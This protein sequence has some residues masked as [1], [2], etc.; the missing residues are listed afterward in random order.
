MGKVSKPESLAHFLRTYSTIR[1]GS[2]TLRLQF[3]FNKQKTKKMGFPFTKPAFNNSVGNHTLAFVSYW[4]DLNTPSQTSLV[5]YTKN[6]V[7]ETKQVLRNTIALNPNKVYVHLS[8]ESPIYTFIFPSY[9]YF[10]TQILSLNYLHCIYFLLRTPMIIIGF[11]S[12][13]IPLENFAGA[14][15]LASLHWHTAPRD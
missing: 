2:L 10:P 4:V 12:F 7:H 14:L 15:L 3:L 1:A 6:E 11:S 8:Q 5:I 13:Y 9:L